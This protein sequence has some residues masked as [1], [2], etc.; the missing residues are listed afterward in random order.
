MPIRALDRVKKVVG[1]LPELDTGRPWDVKRT[2]AGLHLY[3]LE[4]TY[5]LITALEKDHTKREEPKD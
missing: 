5:E 2:H 4:K 1:R 3:I